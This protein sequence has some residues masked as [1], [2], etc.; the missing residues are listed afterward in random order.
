MD[1][2]FQLTL[3]EYRLIQRAGSI[4]SH[5]IEIAVLFLQRLRRVFFGWHLKQYKS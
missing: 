5:F 3:K 1:N 4:R 2:E